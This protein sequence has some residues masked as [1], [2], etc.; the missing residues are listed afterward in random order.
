MNKKISNSKVILATHYYIYSASQALR[1]YMRQQECPKLLYISHPLLLKD[2]KNMDKSFGEVSK[3]KKISERFNTNTKFRNV[4]ASTV[5]ETYLSIKW[6]LKTNHKFDLFVGV[7]NL[8]ALQGLILRR[9]GRVKKVVYYT[10]DYFPTRFENKLLNWIY[11]SIDKICV[12]N[13]DE[14]WNVSSMMVAAREEFNNMDRKIY[15]RQYEVPIGI[16]YNDAKVKRFAKID[17]K[18]LIFVGHLLPHMGVDLVIRALPEIAKKVKGIKLE[19]IGGGE[20]EKKLKKMVKKLEM[21]KM[22]KFYGWIRDRGRL[23]E[24]MADGA[25]GMATFNT[26]ILDEKVKNADPGKIKDYMQMGMPVVVTNAI[27]TA[28][29]IEK[30]KA[31]MV[32][33]YDSKELAFAVSKL[34][35]NQKMLKRYRENAK[36]YIEKFDYPKVF[37]PNLARALNLEV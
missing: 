27:S 36:A 21:A 5:L 11:H 35:R 24:I 37:A 26:K 9:L 18:K 29:K 8:N 15:N 12:K 20:E 16:W 34:L 3:G 1:D 32:I 28:D 31:G 17:K 6:V 14:T 13:A 7:D 25:V 22:V 23:E 10:I 30:A 33:N 19:I 4:I 2:A